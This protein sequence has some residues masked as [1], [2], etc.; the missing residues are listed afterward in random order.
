MGGDSMSPTGLK[1]LD[2]IENYARQVANERSM[3]ELGVG[4][5]HTNACEWLDVARTELMDALKELP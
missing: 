4:D 3:C 1:L 5:D 2:L